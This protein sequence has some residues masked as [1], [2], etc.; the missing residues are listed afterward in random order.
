MKLL[1][2]KQQAQES[3]KFSP[4]P[5]RGRHCRGYNRRMSGRA[6]AGADG[7]L[8]DVSRSFYLTLRV[9][10]GA[11]RTQI[12]TAYLLARATDTI[13]DT[14]LVS[15][16]RRV[17]ALGEMR[18]RIRAATSGRASSSPD[19]GE[20]AAARAVHAGGGSGAERLLLERV[21]EALERLRRFE[22]AD[23]ERIRDVLEIIVSG[24]ELDVARFG[25]ASGANLVAIESDGDLDDYTWRVAG[26]VGQFWTRMCR[27]HLFPAARIREEGLL[28]DGIAFGKGLQL[29]NVLR[30]LA[31]D[32]GQGRCYLPREKLLESGLE[33]RDLLDPSVIGRLRPLYDTYLR[34]AESGLAAGRSYTTGLPRGQLRVR[35][36][37]DMP[38]RIGLRTIAR[39]RE[40]NPLDP[41]RRIRITRRE[42]RTV[43]IRSIIGTLTGSEGPP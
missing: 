12:G 38:I 29:V 7:L 21:G 5:N 40:E 42:I 28:E 19:F 30:D 8:R 23:R 2:L 37:C 4:I 1:R 17:A 3:G 9:L 10:P 11:V 18:D 32:L 24:Q 26:C 14:H 15:V 33:P 35:L 39:L 43:V 34:R 13:A 31:G 22:A 36:A 27:A 25:E 41:S 16:S 6:R 20:L